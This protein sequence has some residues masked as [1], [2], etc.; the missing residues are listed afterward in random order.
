M[1]RI[2]NLASAA[3]AA[4]ILLATAGC[5]SIRD[6]SVS[7]YQGVLPMADFR[8]SGSVP[9]TLNQDTPKPSVPQ[10]AASGSSAAASSSSTTDTKPSSDSS[11]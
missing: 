2:G 5:D 3:L 11:K 10:T 1:K 8:P 4:T 6:Y 7:S 9:M